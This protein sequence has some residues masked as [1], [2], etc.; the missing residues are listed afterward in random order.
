MMAFIGKGDQ[1]LSFRTQDA[2]V[3]AWFPQENLDLT[4]ANRGR[5]AGLK[6][7]ASPSELGAVTCRGYNA[8][9]LDSH[10]DEHVLA[11]D[12]KIRGNTQRHGKGANAIL[13]K[14]IHQFRCESAKIPEGMRLSTIQASHAHDDFTPLANREFIKTWQTRR[15]WSLGRLVAILKQVAIFT[16]HGFISTGR[17]ESVA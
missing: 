7:A 17:S 6:T 13:D 5:A 10:G 11:V 9:L 4:R 3:V 1:I 2:F 15:N 8:G 14:D 16:G 12:M